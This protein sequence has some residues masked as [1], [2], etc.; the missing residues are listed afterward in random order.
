M[1]RAI[2]LRVFRFWCGTARWCFVW[3]Q[4]NANAISD[5]QLRRIEA[6]MFGERR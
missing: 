3:R 6:R 1:K 2:I 4:L 5:E